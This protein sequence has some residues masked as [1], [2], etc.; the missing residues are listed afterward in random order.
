MYDEQFDDLAREL[1][2]TDTRRHVLHRLTA[3]PIVGALV[4]LLSQPEESDAAHPGGRLQDRKQR[5]RNHTRHRRKHHRDSR[6][7]HHRRKRRHGGSGGTCVPLDQVCNLAG[8]ACCKP[9]GC[10]PNGLPF[11][12]T[13]QLECK[14]T[15]ECKQ[16]LGTDLVTCET[17]PSCFGGGSCCR[18]TICTD[19]NNCDNG[20]GTCCSTL[21]PGVKRCC[22]KGQHCAP[23]GG[24]AT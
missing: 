19:S 9:A 16:Q 11:L 18:P 17:G 5:R 20:E 7:H 8:T 15:D 13:C 1:G 21:A 12:T 3:L 4:A 10:K 22:P 6:R 23:L 24:C 14:T 2:N